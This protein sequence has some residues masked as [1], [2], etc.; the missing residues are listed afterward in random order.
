MTNTQSIT[1]TVRALFA[2]SSLL[3]RQEIAL[4]K[5]EISEK[6]EQALTG[7]AA[8]AAGALIA[9]TALIVLV[10]AL[11]AALANI[12]PPSVAALLVGIVLAV[13][14]YICVRMGQEQLKA[15]NLKPKR[16]I[17]S[18]ERTAESVQEAV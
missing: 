3:V 16:T 8:I 5:A 4:A 1:D 2:D 9:F 15:E 7:V 10:Q 6:G 13:I 17:D 18:I 11:V 12:M 14:A